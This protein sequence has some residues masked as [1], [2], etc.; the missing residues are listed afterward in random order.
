MFGL[1][2]HADLSLAY[3]LNSLRAVVSQFWTRFI[4]Q[5]DRDLR[6]KVRESLPLQIPVAEDGVVL[7]YAVTPS[8]RR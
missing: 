5:C 4:E 7:L 8:Q 6:V 2:T 1:T 3:D